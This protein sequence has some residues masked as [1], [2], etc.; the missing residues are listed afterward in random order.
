MVQLL[1]EK[2]RH[3]RCALGMSVLGGDALCEITYDV[4]LKDEALAKI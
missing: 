3:A 4:A 1:G 2:G